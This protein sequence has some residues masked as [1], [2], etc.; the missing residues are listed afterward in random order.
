MQLDAHV[1]SLHPV[2]SKYAEWTF[3]FH[4]DLTDNMK[5]LMKTYA[6][7]SYVGKKMHVDA[8]GNWDFNTQEKW[9]LT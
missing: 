5:V 2:D 8:F 3:H 9:K 1:R 6:N 4:V 7:A